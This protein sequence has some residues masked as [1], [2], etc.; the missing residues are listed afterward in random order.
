MKNIK[1]K[2]I[3]FFKRVINKIKEMDRFKLILIIIAVLVVVGAII[4]VI[5]F[6][7]KQSKPE[8]ELT[9]VDMIPKELYKEVELEGFK[10]SNIKFE[11]KDKIFTYMVDVTNTTNESKEFN[12]V[13]ISLLKNNYEVGIIELYNKTTIEAGKSITLKNFSTKNYT[14]I[15]KLEYTLIK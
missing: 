6:K 14:E 13:V 10:I 4:L 9:V 3:S 15:N 8:K 2:V 11:Y 5:H 12:G 1:D 7:N